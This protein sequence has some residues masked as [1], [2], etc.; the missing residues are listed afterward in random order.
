MTG[1]V[2]VVII[3]LWGVVLIPMWL[4]RHEET[5]GRRSAHRYRRAMESLGRATHLHRLG[6]LGM[7]NEALADND[8]DDEVWERRYDD[9]SS[10][11]GVPVMETVVGTA[12]ALLPLAGSGGS[13]PAAR[14]R[15]RVVAILGGALL[16]SAGGA[17]VG[18]LPG[19]LTVLVFFAFAAFVLAAARQTRNAQAAR[20]FARREQQ[21]TE[22]QRARLATAHARWGADAAAADG[23]VRLV[24][25]DDAWAP[26][27]TTL[28]TYVSKDRATKVPRIIDLTAPNREWSG[29]AMVDQAREQAESAEARRA[30]VQ[31][32]LQE[33]FDR[34]MAALEPD[35]DEEVAA[36]A[37]ADFADEDVADVAYLPRAANQ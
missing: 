16:V 35:I 15:Q 20:A 14:R 3:A 1:L 17:I 21:Q 18:I 10:Q 26:V 12:A 30:E 22:S 28:P 19:F 29:Q 23:S 7:G 13:S 37:G 8:I 11:P 31:A 6:H 33:Q 36:W 27:P 9:L 24:T 32:R 25:S 34:E 4:R 2:Y 5:S